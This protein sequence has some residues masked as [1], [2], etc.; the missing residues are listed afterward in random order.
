[1]KVYEHTT[2]PHYEDVFERAGIIV[3]QA[4]IGTIITSIELKKPLIIWHANLD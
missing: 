3:G 2:P 1:M 4:G